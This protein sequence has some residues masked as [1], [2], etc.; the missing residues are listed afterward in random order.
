MEEQFGTP[1]EYY[2]CFTDERS[3]VWRCIGGLTDNQ[4]DIVREELVDA[5]GEKNMVLRSLE[6]LHEQWQADKVRAIEESPDYPKHAS[7]DE[8]Q[9]HIIGILLDD[10]AEKTEMRFKLSIEKQALTSEQREALDK[11]VDI[12]SRVRAASGQRNPQST[13]GTH[14][15]SVASTD[16]P[17][18]VIIEGVTPAA[19]K[20]LRQTTYEAELALKYAD[21]DDEWHHISTAKHGGKGW[22]AIAT[23]ELEQEVRDGKRKNI[24]N[25]DVDN[26]AR[27]V[28][29]RV[30][31]HRKRLGLEKNG[32]GE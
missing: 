21:K 31:A 29:N 30:E 24:P 3:K 9:S 22:T 8:K 1:P 17:V 6:D 27:N 13:D 32:T 19:Q 23:A 12:A 28:Q 20:Q 10:P 18:R 14:Q 11:C 2:V 15:E 26:L 7:D 4:A 25:A 5:F 16:E